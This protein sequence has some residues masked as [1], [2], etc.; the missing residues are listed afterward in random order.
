MKNFLSERKKL[1]CSIYEP[2]WLRLSWIYGSELYEKNPFC[3]R[4]LLTYQR[5]THMSPFLNFVRKH[6]LLYSIM[7]K[8]HIIFE[9]SFQENGGRIE[10]DMGRKALVVKHQRYFKTWQSFQKH[11]EKH[12]YLG[13]NLA[14]LF[15]DCYVPMKT[16]DDVKISNK[17]L[18]TEIHNLSFLLSFRLGNDFNWC[19]LCFSFGSQSKIFGLLDIIA[20]NHAR[21][22]L[23][24]IAFHLIS[25]V[26][27]CFRLFAKK[28][29]ILKWRERVQ[30]KGSL[31]S[32]NND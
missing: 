12:I 23:F 13:L 7:F 22:T 4:L 20:L 16:H 1:S 6:H 31:R 2:I 18:Y 32:W 17:I 26:A 30:K 9:L 15:P 3:C 5:V 10:I 21:F 19:H 29:R 24:F 8:H 14:L 28:M 11:H 25:R 27:Y